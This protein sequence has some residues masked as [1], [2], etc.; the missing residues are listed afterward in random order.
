MEMNSLGD[1]TSV[2]WIEI[3]TIIDLREESFEFEMN[4]VMGVS[5]MITE[6]WQAGKLRQG[7]E[8]LVAGGRVMFTKFCGSVP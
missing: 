5:R 7:F 1:E 3:S 6:T 2:F 8:A 4:L